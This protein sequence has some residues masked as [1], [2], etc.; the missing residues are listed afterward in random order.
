MDWRTHIAKGLRGR[1]ESDVPMAVRTSVRVGG[2][3]EC[4]VRPADVEDLVV[5]LRLVS[6]AGKPLWILGGG[7]NT[8]V[9]DGGIPGV[10]L[11]L[12]DDDDSVTDLGD[13][14]RVELPA[15]APSARL[16]NHAKQ[17]GLLGAEWAAG[18]PGT[19]GGMTAM[20]AGTRAGEMKDVTSEALLVGPAGAEWV[21]SE[22]LQFAYRHSEL[23]GKVVARVRCTMRK[24]T[25]DEVATSV[26]AM[27]ADKAYRKR[28]QPLQLPNSGSV[29]RNPPGTAAG[30]LTEEAGLKGRRE[31][32]A[33]VSEQHA[34][35][36]VNRGGAT[37]RDVTT[38]MALVQSTVRE[39]TS[40]ELV[41]EVRLVGTFTPAVTD[42]GL[43]V[44]DRDKSIQ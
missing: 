7:A 17:H 19:V 6:E 12:V 15:G 4:F 30:R 10:T 20:N 21:P 33:Q 2:A 42:L 29:F 5:L 27:E 43:R 44:P 37:A 3:A 23:H 25:P 32:G 31:G 24:G 34:N 16:V 39:R 8:L 13:R 38:L 22:R 18:I 36:I 26:E 41:P 11:K 1:V 40:I 28:T 14:V 9:G 35:F